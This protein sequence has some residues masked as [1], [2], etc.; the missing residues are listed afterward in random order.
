EW[1]LSYECLT[2]FEAWEALRG[3]KQKDPAFWKELTMNN[4][5]DLPS[6]RASLP[7]DSL[8]TTKDE[9]EDLDDSD[10][11]IQ[12]LIAMVVG[13]EIPAGIATHSS[14]LLM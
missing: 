12:T 8:P 1:N 7:E 9:D 4:S 2:S 6:E 10:V 5:L 11:P 3:I 14:G 13:D